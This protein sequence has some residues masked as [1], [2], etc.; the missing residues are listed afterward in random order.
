M[1]IKSVFDC[2]N[3]FDYI[4][5]PENIS[6]PKSQIKQSFYNWIDNTKEEHPFWHYEDGV[7]MGLCYRGDAVVYWLNKHI[8]NDK[9][10]KDKARILDSFSSE[11]LNYDLK[12]RL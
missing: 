12:I 8:I 5:C 3:D 10:S 6:I 11:N 9:N 1:I 2:E 7:L 4:Y